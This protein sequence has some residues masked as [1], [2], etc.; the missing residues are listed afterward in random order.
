MPGSTFGRW[1]GGGGGWVGWFHMRGLP[2]HQAVFKEEQQV[3]AGRGNLR[4]S[5][6][7]SG[8][9][10]ESRLFIWPSSHLHFSTSEEEEEGRGGEQTDVWSGSSPSV[11]VGGLGDTKGGELY[12]VLITVLCSHVRSHYVFMFG[13]KIICKDSLRGLRCFSTC[14]L[15]ISEESML[16]FSTSFIFTKFD[17]VR[18]LSEFPS[19]FSCTSVFASQARLG[20]IPECLSC[21]PQCFHAVIRPADKGTLQTLSQDL[22]SAAT[23]SDGV[24]ELN[25]R[26]TSVWRRARGLVQTRSWGTYWRRACASPPVVNRIWVCHSGM[27][28][29]QVSHVFT[30]KLVQEELK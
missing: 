13:C 30:E 17:R 22:L 27:R 26:A 8:I 25:H 15:E 7:Q 23:H 4:L 9:A 11:N 18:A 28:A 1:A 6:C 24:T 21:W 14:Q 10:A 2:P 3:A 12:M 19:Q 20:R 16:I 29:A 5:G